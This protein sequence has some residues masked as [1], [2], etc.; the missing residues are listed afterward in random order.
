M[1][2]FKTLLL[3]GA[4]LAG[5]SGHAR[6]D[7]LDQQQTALHE[8]RG[9][10]DGVQDHGQTFSR[11]ERGRGRG[12]RDRRAH[13]SMPPDVDTSGGGLTAFDFG[14]IAG[15]VLAFHPPVATSALIGFDEGGDN[16]PYA[17]GEMLALTQAWSAYGLNCDLDFETF[18]EPAA[19]E[20]AAP[21][22]P[23]TAVPEPSALALFG[24][25]LFGIGMI[26]PS[27]RPVPRG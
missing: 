13:R 24:A 17:R 20:L 5:L 11:P 1:S 27:H 7:I 23:N 15:E 18:V 19:S 16:D 10:L 12:W 2:F 26:R 21:A 14:N 3:A 9:I 22:Q 8:T 25:G 4:A 6:A